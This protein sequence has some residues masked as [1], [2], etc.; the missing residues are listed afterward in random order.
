MKLCGEVEAMTVLKKLNSAQIVRP[1]RIFFL[2]QRARP[3]DCWCVFSL[4]FADCYN[5]AAVIPDLCR[6]RGSFA[7]KWQKSGQKL[8][9]VTNRE[10][11]SQGFAF[12]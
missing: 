3:S 6:R 9:V 11:N 12:T 2:N 7:V 5:A 10:N 8:Q 4:V 1:V